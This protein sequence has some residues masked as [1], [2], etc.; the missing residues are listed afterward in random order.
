MNRSSHPN[1]ENRWCERV[2][3]FRSP[4]GYGGIVRCFLI[5]FKLQ[6]RRG[7]APSGA[8]AYIVIGG[9]GVSTPIV[10]SERI[11]CSSE[12]I[13]RNLTLQ[14]LR[15]ARSWRPGCDNVELP[16]PKT[17][18]NFSVRILPRHRMRPRV[19]DLIVFSCFGSG[20]P[21]HPQTRQDWR[22]GAI[23]SH[24]KGF[25]RAELFSLLVP[26]SG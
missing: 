24:G 19:G 23:I 10:M 4:P 22:L 11:R 2:P 13:Y 25:S 12:I 15:P 6:I 21:Q 5:Y 26:V 17:A 16:V 1:Y 8:A 20:A 7:G 9:M 18:E 3:S 14:G